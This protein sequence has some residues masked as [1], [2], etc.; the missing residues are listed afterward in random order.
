MSVIV[1]FRHS[2]QGNVKSTLLLRLFFFL[3]SVLGL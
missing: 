3:V 1:E 2:D